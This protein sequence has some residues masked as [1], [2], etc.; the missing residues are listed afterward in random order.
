MG[1]TFDLVMAGL[2][3]LFGLAVLWALFWSGV[4]WPP[5]HKVPSESS[6]LWLRSASMVFATS[7]IAYAL[8]VLAHQFDFISDF[9]EMMLGAMIA[10]PF[11]ASALPLVWYRIKTGMM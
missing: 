7:M 3:L 4:K 8:L 1:S 5:E 2:A 11:F 9:N 10:I 6:R